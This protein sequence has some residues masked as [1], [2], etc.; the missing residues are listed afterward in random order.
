MCADQGGAEAAG[1]ASGLPDHLLRLVLG[2]ADD[3]AG[4]RMWCCH[5]R[6]ILYSTELRR[7]RRRGFVV[8]SPN[9]L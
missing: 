3:N 8:R 2:H 5:A 4:V 9:G 6:L 1:E 7:A